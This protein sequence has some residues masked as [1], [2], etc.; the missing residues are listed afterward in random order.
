MTSSMLS[1]A[2]SRPSSRW[3]RSWAF[4]QV[5][6][7][8]ADDDLLLEGQIL[9]DD[10]AQGE[11][12]RLGLV[13]FTRASILMAKVVCSWVCANRRLSTTCGLASRFSSMTIRIPLRSDSS[14]MSEMPSSRLSST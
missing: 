1:W 5:I 8:A 4:L 13:L 11:D 12:L 6:A 7:G 2:M 9:V 10:V 3:A 14:R